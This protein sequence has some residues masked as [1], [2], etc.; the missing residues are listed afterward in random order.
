VT[1][2]ELDALSVVQAD[3]RHRYRLAR[4]PVLNWQPAT[5]PPLSERMAA[6]DVDRGGASRR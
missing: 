5:A 6:A 2:D 1:A 3:I 4:L